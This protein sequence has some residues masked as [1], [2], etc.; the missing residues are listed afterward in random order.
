MPKAAPVQF[1]LEAKIAVNDLNALEKSLKN[2][3]AEIRGRWRE[4]DRFFDFPDQRLKKSDS[5]LRL[6]RRTDP[7][8]ATIHWTITF[9][10]PKLPGP[11]KH[12]R[13]I[14]LPIHDPDPAEQLFSALGL[15]E[16]V[17]YSKHRTSFNYR[18]C[19]VELDEL[20]NIGKFIEVEGPNEASIRQVLNDLAL[21]HQPTITRSYLAMVIEHCRQTDR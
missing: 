5:A 18:H 1:E 13:E 3:G 8:N 9:K 4:T 16:F 15:S 6:R 10:G 7:D 20:E 14:E 2:L 11:F 21:E 19:I 17:S 12:R